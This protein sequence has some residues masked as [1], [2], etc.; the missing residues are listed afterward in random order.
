MYYR[1][2]KPDDETWAA[3]A[4]AVFA[5]ITISVPH[6]TVVISMLAQKLFLHISPGY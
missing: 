3:A 5:V 6:C 4:A 1:E 2:G